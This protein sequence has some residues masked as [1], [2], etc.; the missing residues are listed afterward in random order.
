MRL[1]CVCLIFSLT[2]Q[3]P[4][5]IITL[6]EL[7]AHTPPDHV[8]KKSLENAREKL[9]D[10]SRQMHDEVSET[11]NIR[12]NLAIE[13]MIV[14]GCD[15]LLDVNQ[16]FVRQG[17]LLQ[18]MPDRQRSRLAIMKAEREVVRQCFLFSNHLII[19]TRTHG[20]RLHLLDGVGKISLAEVRLAEDPGEDV[21]GEE[22]ASSY[23]SSDLSLSSHSDISAQSGGHLKQQDYHG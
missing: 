19:T 5:Y 21:A 13:R 12:K 6:H 20:G 1:C 2:P 14:E 16:V 15:L 11:E 22:E 17:T 10:L 23:S 7:L 9:E 18:V 8:E 4:R 3:I